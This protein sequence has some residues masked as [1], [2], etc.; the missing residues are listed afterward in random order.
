MVV[1]KQLQCMHHQERGNSIYRQLAKYFGGIVHLLLMGGQALK[2]KS[3]FHCI[4]KTF[5]ETLNKK[6]RFFKLTD[7]PS[8][9][10]QCSEMCIHYKIF[11]RVFLWSK[12]LIIIIT[13]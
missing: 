10:I 1:S 7:H 4:N 12:L 2:K 8:K 11:V 9:L 5:V 13:F 3:N 6:K